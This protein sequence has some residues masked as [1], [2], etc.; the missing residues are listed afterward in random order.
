[1]RAILRSVLR[2]AAAMARSACGDPETVSGDLPPTG[3]D[4]ESGVGPIP[5]LLSAQPRAGLTGL[6]SVVSEQLVQS[7]AREA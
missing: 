2:S 3:D 7:S 1:M 6:P 5:R 4:P